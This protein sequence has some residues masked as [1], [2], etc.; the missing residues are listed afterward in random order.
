MRLLAIL[1]MLMF[2][3]ASGDRAVVFVCEHGA[4]K[5]VIATAYFNKLAAE[6]GLPYRATFRGTAPQ[7]D[8]SVRAV[9][10][11][12]ADGVAV[13]AGKPTAISDNDVAGATH[14]FAIGCTLPDK[15]RRSGKAADWSDV[16]DDQ[17]YGPMRDA[18]VTHVKQLLD[19]L[20]KRKPG[21]LTQVGAIELPRV[22]GRI[23]H[24]AFDANSQ[25]LFLAALG[26]NTVEVLDLKQNTHITSLSGFREPQGIAVVPEARLVAVANGQ[27]E[28]LQLL[29]ADDYRRGATVKLGDDSDNVRYDAVAQRL[30]VGFGS[31]ALAT[32][33][34]SDMKALGQVKL[35]GHPE[36]F[37]PERSG[38][39]VFVNVPTADQ[40]A[41]V[42]RSA[43]KVLAT[44]RVTTARANFP[45]ALDEA[46]HRLFVGCRRPAK[47]LVYD[48]ATGQEV[49]SFDI[50]GDT[51]DLFYDVARKRLYVSGGEG[52]IDVFQNQDANRFARVAH[53]ATAAGART[54]LFVADLN[55][56]YLAVPH[57]GNQRAEV[58]IFE[59]R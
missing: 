21:E 23:D 12:K 37:Q 50:V 9:A 45:M 30:Y 59:V 32:V 38:P 33:G 25:R 36:S 51:D 49:G 56:L 29:N 54:S 4:A 8:L 24:L 14:I 48:T 58:R 53:M 39:R 22:E 31:G 46:N 26:N 6:R 20:Q 27:G 28:G 57:R 42:D 18:I 17:G 16:P 2:Q 35:P 44:W 19:E 5:S 15:A 7:D 47:A 3:P 41:V 11:L 52:F 34:P 10:G 43:M 13:P 1:L 55:R 40:I